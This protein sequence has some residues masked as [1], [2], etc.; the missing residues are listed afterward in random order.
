M[1][2]KSHAISGAAV[3]LG[4]CA[5]LASVGHPAGIIAMVAGTPICAAAA[6]LPD[7]DHPNSIA[8]RSLGPV[9]KLLAWGISKSCGHRGLTHT[10]VAAVAVGGV[11]TLGAGLGIGWTWWWLGFAIGLGHLVHILGDCMTLSACPLLW[12]L[13]IGRLPRDRDGW[14]TVGLWYP[15]RFRTGKRVELFFVRP[16]LWAVTVAAAAWLVWPH[17]HDLAAPPVR[18]SPVAT[19]GR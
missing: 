10:G 18:P 12:P 3:W 9:T 1:M 13:P 19:L 5:G 7:L 2:G 4:G 6:L 14:R 17:V 11:A 15:L 16:M 8:S